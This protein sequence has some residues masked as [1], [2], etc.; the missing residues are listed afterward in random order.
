MMLLQ[1]IPFFYFRHSGPDPE[2][3]EFTAFAGTGFRV[4]PG[5][6]T[7]CNCIIKVTFKITDWHF[8]FGGW[9]DE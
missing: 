9:N 5:M 4:K 3:S 7:F 2:S 8:K 1:K 6:T